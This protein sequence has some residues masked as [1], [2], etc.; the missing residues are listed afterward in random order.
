[1]DIKLAE[2]ITRIRVNRGFTQ[3]QIADALLVTPQSVSRWENGQAY[4]DMEMLPRIA[5]FFG[6]STDDLLGTEIPSLK[7]EISSL[8]K[9]KEELWRLRTEKKFDGGL[10]ICEV[11][12]DLASHG[13]QQVEFFRESLAYSRNGGDLTRVERARA[14]CREM[15]IST[16]AD[17]R[18]SELLNI[19]VAEDD[20]Y[21]GRWREFIT[22][23]PLCS[24]WDDILLARYKHNS[25]QH[26]KWENQRQK[27]VY[28]TVRKLLYNMV[29]DMP[30]MCGQWKSWRYQTLNPYEHYKTALDTLNLYSGEVGDVFI[31]LRLYIEIRMAA[32]LFR[33]E[34]KGEGF[35]V[36][37]VIR[38]HLLALESLA[39]ET[40][41]GSVEMLSLIEMPTSEVF[42]RN[43]LGDISY[44]LHRQEFDSVRETPRFVKFFRDAVG[45]TLEDEEILLGMLP[46]ARAVK[47]EKGDLV[48]M[49]MTADG[50]KHHAVIH[51]AVEER[52]NGEHKDEVAFAESLRRMGETDIRYVVCLWHEGSIELPSH[53]FSEKLY[54]L[55]PNNVE[56]KVLAQ[57]SWRYIARPLGKIYS[58]RPKGLREGKTMNGA[59]IE[60]AHTVMRRILKETGLNM[61]IIKLQYETAEISETKMYERGFDMVF[62]VKDGCPTLS[63]KSTQ[64][65]GTVQAKL[66]DLDHGMGFILWVKNGVIQSLEGYSYD[67]KLPEFPGKYTLDWGTAFKTHSCYSYFQI[68]GDFDPDELFS[69]LGVSVKVIA[70][71]G[72]SLGHG[73]QPSVFSCADLERFEK[74]GADMDI[75]DVIRKT[76]EHLLP[77]VER[78]AEWRESMGLQYFL[79]VGACVDSNFPEAAPAMSLAPDVIEF[80]HRTGARHEQKVIFN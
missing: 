69:E 36:L 5:E 61:P 68:I 10:R 50:T 64:T 17:R 6:V 26:Q 48:L 13:C 23:E 57:S 59:Y 78:L 18:I 70:K 60:M 35:A 76:L 37:D 29:N 53:G 45:M 34:R 28:D 66:P 72:E 80:L 40:R 65:I 71:K 14:Y 58:L 2:N 47:M 41:R 4:P 63:D 19:V 56:A 77:H 9:K 62:R 73:N 8:K 43:C 52:I 31:D 54:E 44:Q 38:D 30:P 12:E 79:R 55:N 25:D 21:V 42:V 20:E 49:V 1:M 74:T 32:A 3:R 27:V 46:E 51:H 67:E 7:T 16:D 39:G 15:L 11:L 24:C 33:E 22:G 75:N